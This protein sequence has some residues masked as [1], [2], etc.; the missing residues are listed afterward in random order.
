MWP[1]RDLY[2]AGLLA[3]AAGIAGG[4]AGHF[5]KTRLTQV[6]CALALLGALLEFGASLGALFAAGGLSWTLPSGVPY[7]AYSVR[8]DPLAAFFNLALSFIAAAVSIYSG[9]YIAHT[10]PARVRACS[11]PGSTCCCFP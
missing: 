10:P 5:S 2:A 4:L 9:G 6:L 11:A 8:L 1:V 7:L 3:Y